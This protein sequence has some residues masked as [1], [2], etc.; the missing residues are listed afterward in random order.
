MCTCTDLQVLPKKEKYMWYPAQS[1]K[2]INCRLNSA[3]TS[4]LL[5]FTEVEAWYNA[6]PW[7]FFPWDTGF[8]LPWKIFNKSLVSLKLAIIIT[9][10]PYRKRVLHIKAS[11]GARFF[12]SSL[13]VFDIILQWCCHKRHSVSFAQYCEMAY[14]NES[15]RHMCFPETII[16]SFGGITR[17]RGQFLQ[18]DLHCPFVY[19]DARVKSQNIADLEIDSV[20]S[21]AMA[22]E[23]KP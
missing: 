1:L 16:C 21:E 9:T 3:V 23:T 6:K 15:F 2:N 11:V 20:S 17:L 18:V 4:S 19:N 10:K 14:K 7:K 8:G 12:F 22:Q 13:L 5:G